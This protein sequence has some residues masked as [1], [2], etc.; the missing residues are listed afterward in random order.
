MF[1]YQKLVNNEC[2]H[3]IDKDSLGII[4]EFSIFYTSDD[5]PQIYNFLKKEIIKDYDLNFFNFLMFNIKSLVIFKTAK[6]LISTHFNLNHFINFSLLEDE[7]YDLIKNYFNNCSSIYDIKSFIKKYFWNHIL[8]NRFEFLR[9]PHKWEYIDN[10]IY[11]IQNILIQELKISS[12]EM[13]SFI[14][15]IKNSYNFDNF[16]LNNFNLCFEDNLNIL[17]LDFGYTQEDTEIERL[18]FEGHIG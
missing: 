12:E 13:D 5:N 8:T 1:T 17:N 6:G 7:V 2:Y 11:F 9:N 15:F 18:I 10:S 4:K 3:N 14:N 16:S